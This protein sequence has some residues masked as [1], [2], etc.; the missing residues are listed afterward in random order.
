MRTYRV[1]DIETTGM[2]PPAEVIEIGWQDV[3]LADREARLFNECGA[4]LF[5]SER[6]C[7]PEVIA[8]HHITAEM[9][10]HQPYCN[11]DIIRLHLCLGAPTAL[12]AHN[13]A[14]EASF[15]GD[16]VDM[17]WI[18][19]LKAASRVWPDAPGHSNQVLRY[20]LGLE[21]DADLAMP[22]HRAGPDAYVTAHIFMRLLD[23]ATAEQMIAWT[24]E[25]RVMPTCPIGKFRGHKWADVEAGFLNWMLNQPT[26]EADL[27]WNAERELQRRRASQ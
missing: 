11:E 7:P 20:W 17:P 1:I 16:A 5:Q 15:L 24:K 6:P 13:A 10:A 26:M 4:A 21:L 14:F 12:V 3:A 9:Q 25:P 22:P 23:Y 18:C 19:T 2:E 8:V 27:K